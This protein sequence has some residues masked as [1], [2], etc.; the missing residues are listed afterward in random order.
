MCDFVCASKFVRLSTAST[1]IDVKG[2]LSPLPATVARAFLEVLKASPYFAYP[3]S[4][5]LPLDVKMRTMRWADFG[6]GTS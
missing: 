4:L 6:L 3:L 5:G 1:A 2:R